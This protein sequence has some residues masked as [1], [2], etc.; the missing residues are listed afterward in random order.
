[1]SK[2]IAIAS[3]FEPSTS[4]PVHRIEPAPVV[5]DA[6][7]IAANLSTQQKL[8][9]LQM[10]KRIPNQM[11]WRKMRER[12][13]APP[14]TLSTFRQ[15][16]NDGL[17]ELL[18]DSHYHSLTMLGAQVCDLVGRNLVREENIHA[19]WMGSNMGGIATVNC[20]CGWSAGVPRGTQTQMKAMRAFSHHMA[21]IECIETLATLAPKPK[22]EAT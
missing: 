12:F 4:V 14:F 9:L 3:K 20:T 22:A 10:S 21:S 18:P 15:L 17:A 1:M 19:S 13:D 6:A 5:S 8:A 2:A 16:R 7:R 11:I